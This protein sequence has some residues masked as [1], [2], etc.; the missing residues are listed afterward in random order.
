MGQRTVQQNNGLHVAIIMDGNGRWARRR[1]RPR[2]AGHRAGATAV[3]RVVE[4]AAEPALGIDVL[5]LYAF[6]SDNWQ[7]PPDEVRNLMRLLGDYLVRE[8][9]RCIEN[10]VRLTVTGRRDRLSPELRARIAEAERAT[11][12]AA[13]GDERLT[14]RLAIDYSARDVIVRAAGRW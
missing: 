11:A 1:R 3:R 7:R 9:P 14:L 8:T 12:E 10:R 6:S 13:A 2:A 5:T 4:A